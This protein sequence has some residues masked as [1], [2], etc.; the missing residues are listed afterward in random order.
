M[1][2]H[3]VTTAQHAFYPAGPSMGD[4]F[5]VRAGVPAIASLELASCF[6]ESVYQTLQKMAEDPDA[7]VI[8]GAAHLTAMA[9]GGIGAVACGLAQTK[10]GDV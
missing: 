10:G 7:D 8:Y 6:L 4:L 2:A 9:R 5:D 3:T 1:S